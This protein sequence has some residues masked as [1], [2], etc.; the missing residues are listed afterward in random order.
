MMAKCA[1]KQIRRPQ[2]EDFNYNWEQYDAGIKSYYREF[3]NNQYFPRLKSE[4]A[5]TRFYRE[6][7]NT[8]SYLR[9][10]DIK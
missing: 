3:R 6:A 7:F 10:F 5:D 8:C 4:Y 2:Y 9:D 1:Q